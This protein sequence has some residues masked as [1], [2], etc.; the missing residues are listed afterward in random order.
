MVVDTYT[1]RVFSGL[2]LVDSGI[3]YDALKAASASC[4]PEDIVI[5]QEF[6]A[7]IVEHAKQHYS[8]RPYTD[9]VLGFLSV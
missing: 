7:L 3:G 2:G 1:R 6:H 4:L 5:R 8:R 9:P